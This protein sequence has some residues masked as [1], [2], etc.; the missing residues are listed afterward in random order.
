MWLSFKVNTHVRI[1]KID[2]FLQTRFFFVSIQQIL[3]EVCLHHS[4]I[5]I[6]FHSGNYHWIIIECI[7]IKCI[8][9][10][11]CINKNMLQYILK[12]ADE[13][14]RYCSKIKILFCQHVAKGLNCF[15]FEVGEGT[16]YLIKFTW[17]CALAESHFLQLQ[18]CCWLC[19]STGYPL[20]VRSN[21]LHCVWERENQSE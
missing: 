6:L 14:K 4:L 19:C 1:Y 9:Y 20:H 17:S 11:H 7:S 2:P 8:A 13:K 3:N 16:H 15:E 5:N 12:C 10:R 18:E 21:K